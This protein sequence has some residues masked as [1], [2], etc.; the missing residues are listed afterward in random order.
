M[1]NMQFTD[2]LKHCPINVAVT[3]RKIY[4]VLMY[5]SKYFIVQGAIYISHSYMSI[6]VVKKF[7]CI[8][9]NYT[10]RIANVRRAF[11]QLTGQFY[12]NAW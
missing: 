5:I 11:F 3:G 4:C 1:S 2:S 12:K 6:H 7:L 9:D 8:V 10:V